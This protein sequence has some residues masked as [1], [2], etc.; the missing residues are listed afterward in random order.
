MKF[1]SYT[2]V[3]LFAG[4]PAM[5]YISITWYLDTCSSKYTSHWNIES[6]IMYNVYYY[7]V[8]VCHELHR[9]ISLMSHI[10]KIILRVIMARSRSKTRPEIGKEQY[11]FVEDA[12]TRNAILMGRILSKRAIKMQRDLYLCFIDYTKAFEKVQHEELLKALQLRPRW[13]GYSVD[14]KF[15]LGTNGMHESW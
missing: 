11:G 1:P 13:K 12:G 10:I 2:S 8:P 4:I 9:T 3:I 15:I 14:Q 6:N 7:C 5:V